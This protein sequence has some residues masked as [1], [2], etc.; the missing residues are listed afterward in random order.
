MDKLR[1]SSSQA[2]LDLVKEMKTSSKR[3]FSNTNKTREVEL[4]SSA[5][6]FEIKAL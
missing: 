3:L 5:S 1:I 4:V 6:G 2:E